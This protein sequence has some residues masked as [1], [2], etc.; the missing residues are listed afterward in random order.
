MQ[1]K[2]LNSM[3]KMTVAPCTTIGILLWEVLEHQVQASCVH[4]NKFQTLSSTLTIAMSV[5]PWH[6]RIAK[7]PSLQDKSAGETHLGLITRPLAQPFVSTFASAATF[8]TS[9][10]KAAR[11]HTVASRTIISASHDSQNTVNR[12]NERTSAAARSVVVYNVR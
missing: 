7:D 5:F 10:S 11:S 12:L 1:L 9:T 8:P 4:L 3:F 2:H 6:D